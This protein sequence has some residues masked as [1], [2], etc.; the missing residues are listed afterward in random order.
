ML[1]SCKYPIYMQHVAICNQDCN[2]QLLCSV[3]NGKRV[4]TLV[5]LMDGVRDVEVTERGE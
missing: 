5:L 2:E 4:V 1:W 3:G